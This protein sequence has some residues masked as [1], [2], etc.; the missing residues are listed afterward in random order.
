MPLK[1]EPEIKLNPFGHPAV[2]F[3]IREAKQLRRDAISALIRDIAGWLK[4]TIGKGQHLP[5]RA[6]H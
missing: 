5:M 1:Y 2:D 4:K 3:Y 6:V